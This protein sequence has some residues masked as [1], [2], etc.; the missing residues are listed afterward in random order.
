[1]NGTRHTSPPVIQGPLKF[2]RSETKKTHLRATTLNCE[3]IISYKYPAALLFELLGNEPCTI[4][5]KGPFTFF[6]HFNTAASHP[7]LLI[8]MNEACSSIR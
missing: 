6:Q 3:A 5:K 4:H 1:M 8:V 7:L 2:K